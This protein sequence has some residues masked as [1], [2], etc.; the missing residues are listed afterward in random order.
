[1]FF[2]L[3]IGIGGH[4]FS[5]CVAWDIYRYC[6]LNVCLWRVKIHPVWFV[7][8]YVWIFVYCWTDASSWGLGCFE[9]SF[10]GYSFGL[11]RV[12]SWPNVEISPSLSLSLGGYVD[13]LD[14]YLK[15][16]RRSQAMQGQ[17]YTTMAKYLMQVQV[18]CE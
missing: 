12:A 13:W 9:L 18:K 14:G 4:L 10:R 11:D 7:L 1:M 2:C 6:F 3:F 15:V 17:V 16:I 8:F 5:S